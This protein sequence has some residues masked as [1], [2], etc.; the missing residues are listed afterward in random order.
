MEKEPVQLLSVEETARRLNL[1]RKSVEI[2]ISKG[3]LRS[4]KIGRRRLLRLK[5]LQDFVERRLR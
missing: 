4:L 2:R 5:D 3:E 1:C